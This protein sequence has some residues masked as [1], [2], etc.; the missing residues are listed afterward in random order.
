MEEFSVLFKGFKTKEQAECFVRW[1]EGIGEQYFYDHLDICGYT[2]IP[3]NVDL[4]KTYPL[5][6]KDNTYTVYLG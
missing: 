1:Y 3:C 5:E 6:L 2:N 4:V